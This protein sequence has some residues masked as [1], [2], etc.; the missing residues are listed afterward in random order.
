LAALA[1]IKLFVKML[2]YSKENLQKEQKFCE[3]K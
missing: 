1:L 3:A 2:K